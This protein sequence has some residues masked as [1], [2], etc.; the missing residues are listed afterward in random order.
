MRFAASRRW[1]S[2]SVLR[3][4]FSNPLRPRF[5]N[6]KFRTARARPLRLARARRGMARSVATAAP[7]IVLC[8]T[9]LA[10]QVR[11]TAEPTRLARKGQI[12]MQERSG[13]V[14]RMDSPGDRQASPKIAE[15]ISAA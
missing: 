4:W 11:Q 2:T 8:Q 1:A 5:R 6:R 14:S 3:H 7:E 13:A 9:V 12:I 10:R 15:Y